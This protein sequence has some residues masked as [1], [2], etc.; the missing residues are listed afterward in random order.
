VHHVQVT[1]QNINRRERREN[2]QRLAANADNSSMC[3]LKLV[4][5]LGIAEH[6]RSQERK[7][8][9]DAVSFSTSMFASLPTVF[10]CEV[11][12]DCRF[13]LESCLGHGS[14][15]I[16]RSYRFG[17]GA[18]GCQSIFSLQ[19]A[20]CLTHGLQFSRMCLLGS[21]VYK[22]LKIQDC[23][24]GL[25]RDPITFLVGI[26]VGPVGHTK[27]VNSSTLSWPPRDRYGVGRML[28]AL[29]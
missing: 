5:Y 21:R 6:A 1:P 28:V 11:R 4:A 27:N 17:E 23:L 26:M 29:P 9:S 22:L 2:G 8:A 16:W 20:D 13:N 18:H 24:M 25:A 3:S 15:E 14:F 12:S 10:G 19:T 7:I